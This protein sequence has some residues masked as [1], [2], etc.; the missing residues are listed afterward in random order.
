MGAAN[1]AIANKDYNT[2]LQDYQAAANADPNNAG[3]Y[4]G[5]GTCYYYLG[6]KA[7]ALT[8]FNKALQLNP[9]NTQLSNFVKALSK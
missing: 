1:Q 2:A 8:A 7:E 6:Q 4:Q 5:E 3:A 9:G